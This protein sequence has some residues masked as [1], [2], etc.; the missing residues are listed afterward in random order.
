M[1]KNLT[2]KTILSNDAKICRSMISK[3]KVLMFTAKVKKPLI[4][5]NNNGKISIHMFFVF[6]PIDVAWLDENKKIVHKQ[7]L[8]P[9]SISKAIKARYVIE[10]K[11]GS[12]NAKIGDKLEFKT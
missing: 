5:V 6:Y 4:F 8:K 9:F 3:L 1:I 12:L 7:T 2:R 10:M 11:A